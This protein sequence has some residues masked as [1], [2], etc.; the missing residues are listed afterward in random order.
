VLAQ[1]SVANGTKKEHP[2][3]WVVTHAKA[4]IVG[5]ALGH[6]AKAH[7]LPEFQA[8]LRTAVNW[9]AGKN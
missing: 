3:V 6:D 8:L 7:D 2:S 4:R 5:I 1:T 9:A